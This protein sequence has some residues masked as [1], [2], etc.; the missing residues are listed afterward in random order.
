[1]SWKYLLSGFLIVLAYVA[2]PLAQNASSGADATR[3]VVTMN[4]TSPDGQSKEVTAPESGIVKITLNDG[5]EFGFRPV[6]Q[7]SKPWNRV[8]VTI[9]KLPTATT[10]TQALG[11]VEIKTGAAAVQSK[12]SPAFKIGVPKVELPST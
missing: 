11:E 4:I 2:T 12:T 7:D 1:M 8:L 5:S 3:P 10:S 9:F 6:I